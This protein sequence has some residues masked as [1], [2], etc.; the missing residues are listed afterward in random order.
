MTLIN[1][2]NISFNDYA[3]FWRYTIGVNVIPADTKNKIPRIKWSE[4]Q[5]MPIPKEMHQQWKKEEL[6]SS[7][8]AIIP[9]K[10]WHRADRKDLYFVVIDVDNPKGLH[11]L[12]TRNGQTSTLEKF[13]QKIIVE[14]HSDNL[15][16]AHLYFYSQVP[17]IGKSPDEVLGIEVKSLGEHGIAFCTPSIHKDGHRYE[18]IGTREPLVLTDS[19]AWEFMHHINQAC[20]QHGLQYLEK[21]GSGLLNDN[22]KNMLQSFKI[23]ETIIIPKGKRHLTLISIANSLLIRHLDNFTED[24]IK[25]FFLQINLKLCHPEPLVDSEINSIWKSAISFA[26]KNRKKQSFQH[27][28]SK[29]ED[30]QSEN[31]RSQKMKRFAEMLMSTHKIRT[32]MDTE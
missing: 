4:F 12:C 32:L 25:N 22:M 28:N 31:S 20:E 5:S 26:I 14:Q 13:S 27:H 18:I 2:P 11:E 17:F 16:R 7:G 6:F 3:D 8:I 1:D 29:T 9:G 19:Q 30:L 15:E 10:V 21:D 24:E 23:D